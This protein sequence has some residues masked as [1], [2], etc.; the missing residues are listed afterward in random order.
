MHMVFSGNPGTGKTTVA[1]LVAE[2]LQ[3]LGYLKRGHLVETDRAGLVAPYVGQTAIKVQSVVES[4]MGGMLFVD[5]AY[6]LVKDAKDSFGREALDT[7]IKMVEDHRDELVV[8]LA[9]YPSEMD[10]LMAHNPGVRSRFPTV[11]VFEDYCLTELMQIA[12]AFIRNHHLTM[13]PEAEVTLNQ[14]LA[15]MLKIATAQDDS[16]ENGNGRAV[17]NIVEQAMRAQAL[18]LADGIKATLHPHELSM[19]DAEDFN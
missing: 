7:L 12:D 16:R 3:A 4:A 13:T 2:L 6:A 8:V 18:R 10:E 17:R 11:I 15:G 5:E 14:K 1:R 19:L 9:G